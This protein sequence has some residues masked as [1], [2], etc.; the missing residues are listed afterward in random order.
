MK[1]EIQPP[2]IFAALLVLSAALHCTY[3]TRQVAEPPWAFV[4]V[5][6]I[7]FGVVLNLWADSLFKR[8]GTTVKPQEIPTALIVSGPFRISRHPMYLGMATILLGEAVVLGSL[9]GLLFPLIFAGL[10]EALFMLRE[11]KMLEEAFGEE[12][13]DYRRRVRRWI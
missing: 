6:L 11:E 7:G 4:G 12:Y 8:C 2:T 13:L 5:L 9:A 3:P 10:M 1:S